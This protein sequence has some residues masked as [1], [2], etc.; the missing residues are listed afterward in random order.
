VGDVVG[1]DDDGEL[2]GAN[3]AGDEV[4]DS[5]NGE[6]VGETVGDTDAGDVLGE[7][8]GDSDDG[9][10]V[11]DSEDGDELGAVDAGD[12]LGASEGLTVGDTVGSGV[13]KHVSKTCT[14]YSSVVSRTLCQVTDVRLPRQRTL[15]PLLAP[16]IS[17]WL[18]RE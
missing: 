18:K 8:V 16:L 12:V 9:D 4:G 10:A 3:D 5:D 17:D 1:A 14:A 15:T 11:G 13:E 2:L 7:A 6:V